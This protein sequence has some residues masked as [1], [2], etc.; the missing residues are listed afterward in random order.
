MNKAE[1]EQ[2]IAVMQ[3]W[4][5]GKQIE[6]AASPRGKLP[7]QWMPLDEAPIWNWCDRVYRIK[8]EPTKVYVVFSGC[9]KRICTKDTMHEALRARDIG[10]GRYVKEFVEV[11]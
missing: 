8:P 3:A 11:L 5:E 6:L 10:T 7:A 9:H 1:T 4:V 2:A